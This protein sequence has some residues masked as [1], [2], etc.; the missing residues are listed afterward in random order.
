MT[1]GKF[2]NQVVLLLQIGLL[3]K[4]VAYFWFS[5]FPHI[6]GYKKE[7]EYCEFDSD[8]TDFIGQFGDLYVTLKLLLQLMKI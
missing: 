4:S 6:L 2:W 3:L 5:K 1:E 7:K 8:Y